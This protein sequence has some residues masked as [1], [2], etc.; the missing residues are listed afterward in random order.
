[1]ATFQQKG[2]QY[3]E[4]LKQSSD[5]VSE[6]N[7]IAKEIDNLVYSKNRKP[8]TLEDKKKIVEAISEQFTQT[9]GE[10]L[11]MVTESDNRYYL[12]LVNHILL[13]LGGKK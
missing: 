6:A 10:K 9:A 1:M 12:E 3:A 4:R 7:A 11:D 13:L 2:F 8:L 5:M